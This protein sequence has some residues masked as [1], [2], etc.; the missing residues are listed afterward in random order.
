MRA[1]LVATAT[2]FAVVILEKASA[3]YKPPLGIGRRADVN[4]AALRALKRVFQAGAPL[5]S[6]DVQQRL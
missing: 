1:Q 6:M 3:A 2:A 5:V 4:W